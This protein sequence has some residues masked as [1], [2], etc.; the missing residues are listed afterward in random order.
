[1]TDFKSEA[2]EEIERLVEGKGIP[3]SMFFV[4]GSAF[5]FAFRGNYPLEASMNCGSI[6]KWEKPGL[7]LLSQIFGGHSP[8]FFVGWEVF[9]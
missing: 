3:W 6:P 5:F 7:S 4:L 9:W 2:A 8:L 1:M